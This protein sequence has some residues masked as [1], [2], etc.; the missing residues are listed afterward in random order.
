MPHKHRGRPRWTG[1]FQNFP[2]A[3]LLHSLSV[4][5][6]SKLQKGRQCLPF[7]QHVRALQRL[8]PSLSRQKPEELGP[9]L[10][11]P[12][13]SSGGK[14]PAWSR[15]LRPSLGDSPRWVPSPVDAGQGGSS[16]PR[17]RGHG[18]FLGTRPPFCLWVRSGRV[19]STKQS[20][21]LQM[22]LP[23]A[24]HPSPAPGFVAAGPVPV[25][26][27]PVWP[28]ATVQ[29]RR[30]GSEGGKERARHT[31][32]VESRFAALAGKAGGGTVL[33][34]PAGRQGALRRESLF[35]TAMERDLWNS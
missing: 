26:D 6:H 9:G 20:R 14:G 18:R 34:H 7:A 27:G 21:A 29:R 19:C 15:G 17:P 22:W 13:A 1:G 24:P 5:G 8:P 2:E 12:R 31:L 16:R 30:R 32:C 35:P 4:P 23:P 10:S 3:P 33:S 25:P 28:E 11:F